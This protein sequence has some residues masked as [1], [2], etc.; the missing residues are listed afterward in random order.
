MAALR[1]SLPDSVEVAYFETT[2]ELADYSVRSVVPGDVLM[3][4][5]SLGLGF[6]KI[7]DA[8]IDN[9]PAFADTEPQS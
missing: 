3:V 7:I 1:D 5:S 4:K 6:R 9:Y 8:L 2:Q